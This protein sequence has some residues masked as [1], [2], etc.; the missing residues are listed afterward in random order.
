MAGVLVDAYRQATLRE[1]PARSSWMLPL[2]QSAFETAAWTA[3]W[4]NNVGNITHVEGDTFDWMYIGAHS[5]AGAAGQLRFRSYPSLGAGAFNLMRWLIA[6]HVLSHADAG[7]LAGY[8]QALQAS[9]YAG[10]DAA[11]YPQYRAGMTRYVT[12]FADV[13]P[14]DY[15]GPEPPKPNAPIARTTRGAVALVAGV[16]A[17]VL[18]VAAVVHR[19]NA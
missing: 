17:V 7:D 9:C 10:C 11:V 19:G 15:G 5:G 13:E 12:K 16:F 8:V 1:P 14:I 18:G 3:M 6:H 2:A 4:N